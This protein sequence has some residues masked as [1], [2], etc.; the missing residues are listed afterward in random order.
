MSP[1]TLRQTYG[2]IIKHLVILTAAVAAGTVLVAEDVI[3]LIFGK[4][5]LPATP[6]LRIL[7]FLWVFSFFNNVQSTL[8]FSIGKERVQ[9]R[10]MAFACVTNFILTWGLINWFGYLGAAA[11]SV[12]TE[13][14]VVL[15]TSTI[16]WRLGYHMHA[17]RY[18]VQ[19]V[20]ALT[21]MVVTVQLLLAVHVVVAIAMG[22]GVFLVGLF[23]FRVFDGDDRRFLRAATKRGPLPEP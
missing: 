23:V 4:Q 1:D 12:L 18:L 17:G 8:L 7:I 10:V 22:A 3:A 6:V 9:V 13:A 5:F 2:R 20:L 21:V 15:A 11:A 14:A 16:L 19:L